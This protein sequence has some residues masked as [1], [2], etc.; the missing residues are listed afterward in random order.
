MH[1]RNLKIHVQKVNNTKVRKYCIQ[2]LVFF[3]THDVLTL[4]PQPFTSHH[5]TTHMPDAVFFLRPQR[6]PYREDS[7]NPSIQTTSRFLRNGKQGTA[8]GCD[9]TSHSAVHHTKTVTGGTS[10]PVESKGKI[11]FP[12][13]HYV[14]NRLAIDSVINPLFQD[15]RDEL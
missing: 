4:S 7:P 3:P 13:M 5:F 1:T 6:L 8:P 12:V 9:L 15:R 14:G 2:F 10:G 11:M